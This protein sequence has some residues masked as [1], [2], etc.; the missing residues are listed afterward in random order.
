MNN[1]LQNIFGT[2]LQLARKMAGY[3]LQDLS[4]ALD[5]EVTKQSLS[6]YEMGLMNPSS[7]VLLSIS[8]A[9]NI[10]PDYFLKKNAV[11]LGEILFRKKST[12]SKKIEDSIVEKVRDYVERYLEIEFIVGID[13]EFRNPIEDLIIRTKEDVEFSANKLRLDWE[14]GV[15]SIS[16]IIEMLELKGIKVFIVDDVEDID[17]LAVLTSKGIPVIVVN[18]KNKSLERI[19]FTIIHELAHLLLNIDSEIVKNSKETELLCHYFAS[20]FLLPKNMLL[21]LIGSAKREYIKLNE[22]VSIK[23]Y[24]GISIRALLHRLKELEIITDIYYRRW[25]IYLNKKYGSQNEPGKYIG[26]E[27]AKNFNLLVNRALAEELIS[28]SKASTLWNID[29]DELRKGFNGVN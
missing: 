15:N 5:N 16:N 2:R 28:L 17:G 24:F 29:I 7:E 20:C 11:E 9:L 23:E 4:D 18:K 13:T 21:K 12:L 22:L 8:K 3:S 10:R 6:K 14:L 1:S 26:E 27:K 19:R 25:S